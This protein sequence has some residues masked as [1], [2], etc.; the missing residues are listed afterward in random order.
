MTLQ[1]SATRQ[2]L[3]AQS[4]SQTPPSRRESQSPDR[5]VQLWKAIKREDIETVAQILEESFTSEATSSG[6]NNKNIETTM[7]NNPTDSLDDATS[8]A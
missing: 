8:I 1:N 5:L 3:S 7:V 4:H 6:D 2:L